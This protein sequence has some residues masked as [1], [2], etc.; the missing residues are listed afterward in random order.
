MIAGNLLCS[1]S[2]VRLFR[3]LTWTRRSPTRWYW[4]LSGI[5]EC[6]SDSLLSSKLFNSDLKPLC[7]GMHYRLITVC[8]PLLP[9]IEFAKKRAITVSHK[10]LSTQ[11]IHKITVMKRWLQICCRSGLAIP[12]LFRDDH[13]EIRVVGA[14]A[15]YMSICTTL[16]NYWRMI[17][18]LYF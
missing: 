10:Y 16:Q 4:S 8:Q 2:C 17:T 5:S 9:D 7:W 11:L 15:I 3:L 12:Q 6:W 18:W 14:V 13:D 1:W